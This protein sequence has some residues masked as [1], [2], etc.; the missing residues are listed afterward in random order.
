MSGYGQIQ[1]VKHIRFQKII[2]D[3]W[4]WFFIYLVSYTEIRLSLSPKYCNY[5]CAPPH[6]ARSIIFI[7]RPC[8]TSFRMLFLLLDLFM[9]YV[10]SVLPACCHVP[11][12]SWCPRRLEEV[13]VIS[14]ALRMSVYFCGLWVK[15]MLMIY[16]K[17]V[18]RFWAWGFACDWQALFMAELRPQPRSSWVLCFEHF[19]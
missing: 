15:V 6:P 16:Q 12:A 3:L 13:S 18:A 1:G 10:W 7:L 11:R 8:N 9:F 14:S 5:R 19:F 2:Q 17:L 4:V